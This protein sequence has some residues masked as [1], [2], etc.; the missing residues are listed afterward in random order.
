MGGHGTFTIMQLEPNYFAA[1]AP[2]AGAGLKSTEDFIDANVIKD[3]PIWAFHGDK[4]RVCPYA[5]VRKVFDDVKKLGG[6]MK[7]TSWKDGN[8]GVSDKFIPGEKGSTT[9][10]TSER[11]DKEPNFLTWLFKQKR[12][13][14]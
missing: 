12:S 10:M 7:L 11:C 1:A 6:N 2:S 14:K 13:K 3:L 5:K 8:H 9:E 4:D